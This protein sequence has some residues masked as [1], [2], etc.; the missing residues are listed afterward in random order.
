[1]LKRLIIGEFTRRAITPL[2]LGISKAELI[3]VIVRRQCAKSDNRIQA[4]RTASDAR[5]DGSGQ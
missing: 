2:T 3:E 4:L 1:M 5:T